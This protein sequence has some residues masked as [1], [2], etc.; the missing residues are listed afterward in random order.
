[1]NGLAPPPPRLHRSALTR[2]LATLAEPAAVQRPGAG[3]SAGTKPGEVAAA[4][5][6]GT[7]TDADSLPTTRLA[8]WLD[9]T[10]AIAL[11]TSLSTSSPSGVPALRQASKASQPGL[12]GPGGQG[13]PGGTSEPVDHAL[14]SLQAAVADL[15][16]RLADN[17][18]DDAVL[19]AISGTAPRP[20]RRHGGRP[21]PAMGTLASPAAAAAA[22]AAG[23]DFA[24]LRRSHRAQQRALD[25]PLAALRHNTRE[26]LAAASPT[27]ARLA[28]L[29]GVLERALAERERHLLG[30]TTVLLEQRFHRLR[31]AAA[32]AETGE[33]RAQPIQPIQPH[34]PRHARQPTPPTG[35]APAWLVGFCRELQALLHAELDMRLQPIEAMM[36]ALQTHAS[37]PGGDPANRGAQ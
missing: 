12:A 24:P 7:A 20:L 36:S 22:A 6:P 29:D 10:D 37:R 25:N 35:H 15:R 4:T 33:A 1:M 28:A 19:A 30:Q 9:W 26:A 31:Q 32:E 5:A 27:L 3:T 23:S 8:A 11:S 2:L 34:P 16:L 14:E 17:L 13:D 18:R 21:L